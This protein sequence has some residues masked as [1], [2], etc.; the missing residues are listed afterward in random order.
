MYKGRTRYQNLQLRD[1]VRLHINL[2]SR[3]PYDTEFIMSWKATI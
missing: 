2:V 3:Q 1:D